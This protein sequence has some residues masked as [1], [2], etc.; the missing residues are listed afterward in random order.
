MSAPAAFACAV[1]ALCLGLPVLA[2]ASHLEAQQRASA[3]ADAAALA[4]ADAASGWV[5]A[6]PCELAD[7]VADA[8]GARASRCEVDP[9]RGEARVEIELSARLG[10][11]TGRARAAPPDPD[12]VGETGG[13]VWPAVGRG[14]TQGLHDGFAIDLDVP[15]GGALLAP[16]SGIVVWAGADEGPV[17]A[18]CQ[19]RPEWWRGP[20]HAVII[21]HDDGGQ[22]RFSS[23][24]HIAPGSAAALGIAAGTPVRAGQP[25]AR[26]GMSGCTSGPHSHFTIASTQRNAY[27]DI[28]PFELLGAPQ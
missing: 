20:N 28:N 14:I 8:Q 12:T 25:V 17:P 19:A 5:D 26:A 16:R 13:W 21:R 23:H 24:H 27:P 2:A 4:A 10:A 1:A 3:I 9:A 7:V 15:A 6:A 11:V 22:P 18:A